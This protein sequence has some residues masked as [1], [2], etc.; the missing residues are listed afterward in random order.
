MSSRKS[1]ILT[2][3]LKKLQ[4]R[5]RKGRCNS[6]DHCQCCYWHHRNVCSITASA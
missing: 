3:A 2:P 6:K 1:T 5:R 4:G